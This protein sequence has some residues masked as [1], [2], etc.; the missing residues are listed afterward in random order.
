VNPLTDEA[1]Q[2]KKQ[3]AV[4][5]RNNRL[6][7]VMVEEARAFFAETDGKFGVAERVFFDSDYERAMVFNRNSEKRTGEWLRNGDS[8]AEV[9]TSGLYYDPDDFG[10]CGSVWNPRSMEI[11]RTVY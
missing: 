9:E 5:M 8:W 4:K 7:T 6:N 1:R 3:E 11:E 10:G 2:T